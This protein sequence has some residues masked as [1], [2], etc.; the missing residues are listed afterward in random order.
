LSVVEKVDPLERSQSDANEAGDGLR[1]PKLLHEKGETSFSTES[2]RTGHSITRSTRAST[3]GGIV[4]PIGL[5]CR[6]DPL[7]R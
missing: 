1:P 6:T 3:D 4:M 7:T 2:A 5:R